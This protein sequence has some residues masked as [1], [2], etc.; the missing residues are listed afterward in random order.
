[1]ARTMVIMKSGPEDLERVTDGL[2][3]CAAMLGM[4]WS[5][6]IVFLDEGVNCLRPGSIH[7]QTIRDY[8]Q[9]SADLAGI[10]AL[11]RSLTEKGIGI[12]DL[13]KTLDIST[14]DIRGL[15]ELIAECGSTVTF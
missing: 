11:S 13:D 14:V 3:L 5:P 4:D 8:L 10:Q 2:R 1:M 6:R 12:E 7:D 9:V 15:G